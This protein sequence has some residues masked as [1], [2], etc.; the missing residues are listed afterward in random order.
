M[1]DG[2]WFNDLRPGDRKELAERVR[3]L[4]WRGGAIEAAVHGEGRPARV[5]LRLSP[6]GPADAARVARVLAEDFE[7]GASPDPESVEAAADSAGVP[8]WPQR[9]R[10]V[11]GTCSCGRAQRPCEHVVAVHLALAIELDGSVLPLVVLRG[12]S[13]ETLHPLL[14]RVQAERPV[15]QA[16]SERAADP[17]TMGEGPPPDWSAL[18]RLPR[19]PPELPDPTGWRNPESFQAL[20]RR[21]ID[22]ALGREEETMAPEGTGTAG[23]GR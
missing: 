20:T 17:F 1:L 5:Q 13:H 9:I 6:L 19:K 7:A 15:L 11:A 21:L 10:E 12:L 18:D 8:L 4:E 16:P 2:G 14:E 22:K 23:R 3:G